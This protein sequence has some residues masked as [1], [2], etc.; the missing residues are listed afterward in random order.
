MWYGTTS[1]PGI[2]VP[3]KPP[4][5]SREGVW[6]GTTDNS[7]FQPPTRSRDGVLYGYPVPPTYQSLERV[8]GMVQLVIH[9]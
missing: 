5:R 2:I 4:T 1:Y 3:F 8:C 9:G 6:Y 7:A